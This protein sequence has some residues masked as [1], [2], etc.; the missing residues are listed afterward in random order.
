MLKFLL[1]HE[2]S[3]A[4]EKVSHLKISGELGMK[5]FRNPYKDE[6]VKIFSVSKTSDLYISLYI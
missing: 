2:F 4:V 5:Q 1:L 6:S 3:A